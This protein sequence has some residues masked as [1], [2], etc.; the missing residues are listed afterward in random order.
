MAAITP[1]HQQPQPHSPVSPAGGGVG[2]VVMRSA[3]GLGHGPPGHRLSLTDEMGRN[4]PAFLQT[5]Q[6]FIRSDH[7]G[8]AHR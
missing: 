6:S 3:G 4:A 1:T 7:E 8:R 5:V 2:A